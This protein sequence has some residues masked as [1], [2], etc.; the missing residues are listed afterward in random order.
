MVRQIYLRGKLDVQL[1]ID[2][3]GVQIGFGNVDE[4]ELVRVLYVL[5]VPIAH[6]KGDQFRISIAT[7]LDL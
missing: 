7:Y 3:V 5:F 2:Y 6:S 4:H 1:G